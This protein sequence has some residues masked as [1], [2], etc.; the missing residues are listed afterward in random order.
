MLAGNA[1]KHLGGVG[2]VECVEAGGG[3][4]AVLAGDAV[5]HMFGWSG[6]V[7]V[8]GE[9][10]GMELRCFEVMLLSTWWDV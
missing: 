1:V 4:A 9:A 6:G 5:Q 8:G 3:G 7:G 10:G 2:G